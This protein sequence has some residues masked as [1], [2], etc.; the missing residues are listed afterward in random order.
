MNAS[1]LA[2]WWYFEQLLWFMHQQFLIRMLIST[3]PTMSSSSWMVYL[4]VLYV[5]FCLCERLYLH[6][7]D[8]ILHTM[9]PPIVDPPEIGTL[10]NNLPAVT[11]DTA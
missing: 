8:G 9:E 5:L 4:F 11:K 7:C 2:T 3:I 6:E 1:Q 10:Y